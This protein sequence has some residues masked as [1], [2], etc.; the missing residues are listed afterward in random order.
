VA[1]PAWMQPRLTFQTS[2]PIGDSVLTMLLYQGDDT[3]TIVM[4]AHKA[5]NQVTV[6]DC[7]Q[8]AFSWMSEGT[9]FSA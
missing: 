3:A 8:D 6:R 1:D 4:K 2:Y 9:A 5:G 7:A